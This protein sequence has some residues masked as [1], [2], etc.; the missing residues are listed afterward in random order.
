MIHFFRL[1][2]PVN[3][4]ITAVTM[5]GLGW[6]LEGYYA[7]GEQF[8]IRSFPFF[9]LVLSTILIAAAGN[10]I[11]DYFDVR[12]DRVNKPEKL[13]IGVHLK[14]RWAIISHWGLNSVAFGIAIYLSWLFQSFWYLFIHL[15]SIN[16]LWGYSSYFK[17]KMLIG[18]FIIAGLTALVPI[19]VS[20]YFH[21]NPNLILLTESDNFPFSEDF[22]LDIVLNV[23]LTIAIF[24]FI[25]NL[26]REIVKDIQDIEG[27]KLLHAKTIPIVLGI[28]VTK[29]ICYLIMTGT[30]ASLFY[31]EMFYAISDFNAMIP[32]WFAT[33]FVLI[34][35][36]LLVFAQDRKGLKQVD[37][38]IKLAMIAGL[39]A[40]VYWKYLIITHG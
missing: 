32:I 20:I 9:L 23:S 26:V 40:P 38:F 37:L 28:K 12:A 29:I 31:F 3:L 10:V 17:R 5:Y 39:L 16:L 18:N 6:Y 22:A 8:G 1:T 7:N 34:A 21:I 15:L 2:R 24:A 4:I 11:N 25:L 14:R 36:F 27:D 19:L 30:L 33:G 13:I 35:L